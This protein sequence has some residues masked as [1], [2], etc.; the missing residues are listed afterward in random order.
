MKKTS[1]L[2]LLLPALLMGCVNL[3]ASGPTASAVVNAQGKGADSALYEVVDITDATLAV[4]RNRPSGDLASQFSRHP[5]A[6]SQ[7]LTIGDQI[8]VTIFEA[9]SGGL[10]S[11]SST[12]G[13]PM[14]SSHSI[15][16]PQQTVDRDGSISVPYAGRITAAGRT[17]GSLAK[18]IEARLANKAVEPQVIVSTQGS[19]ATATVSGDATGSA[20]VAL[21]LKG[22]RLLEVIAQSGGIRTMPQETKVR[23]TRGA[24]SEVTLLD[25]ILKDPSQNVFVYPGD[26]IYVYRDPP[27][28]VALGAVTAQKD[29]PIDKEPM[30]LLQAIAKAGGLH[31]AQADSSAIF[32]FR[33]EEASLVRALKPNS[34]HLMGSDPVPVI[35]RLRLNKADNYFYAQQLA[36]RD[37]DIIYVA[38]SPV[39]QFN[40]FVTMVRGI[41]STAG[42]LRGVAFAN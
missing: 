40:K 39:V 34:T 37:R 26:N 24:L 35:Y 32:L 7:A 4:L 14:G 13:A 5:P 10:F 16:L 20:R 1:H 36:I 23:L 6:P 12:P 22:D 11:G 33:R 3:P 2:L 31:D 41:T 30:S 29:Y 21:S 17:P 38:N 15:S 19:A 28:F 9:A 42:S 8:V 25:T 18:A 27:I